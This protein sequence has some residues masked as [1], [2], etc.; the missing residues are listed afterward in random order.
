MT[1]S[2]AV[3][4]ALHWWGKGLH[5][6]ERCSFEMACARCTDFIPTLTALIRAQTDVIVQ[7]IS[8]GHDGDCRYWN[9]VSD[10]DDAEDRCSC[11]IR[12]CREALSVP[13]PEDYP[14]YWRVG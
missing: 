11:H 14:D 7:V 1:S 2:E 10:M 8:L 12:K 6:D 5:P 4:T 3:Q 13:T 9:Y